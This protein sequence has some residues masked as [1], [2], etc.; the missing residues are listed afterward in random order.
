MTATELRIGNWCYSSKNE[1]FQ[2]NADD[3]VVMEIISGQS[4]PSEIQY[5]PIP[6]TEEW[7]LKFGFEHAGDR[8]VIDYKDILYAVKRGEHIK[9]DFGLNEGGLLYHYTTLKCV[10]QLQ[11]LYFALTGTELTN[12]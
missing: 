8:Y 4:S 5:N 3:L 10:H 12:G 7:F 2:V 9:F 11:N 6:L 1:P